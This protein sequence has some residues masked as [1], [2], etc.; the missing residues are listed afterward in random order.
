MEHLITEGHSWLDNFLSS[1]DHQ[2]SLLVLSGDEL[3]RRLRS[4]SLDLQYDRATEFSPNI[5]TLSMLAAK[6]AFLTY[7]PSSPD[8][9]VYESDIYYY[10][11]FPQCH[12]FVEEYD[13]F[14]RSII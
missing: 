14:K 10:K 3:A 5:K 4:K 13:E 12:S 11:N 2:K 1:P 6:V 8:L 9:R 7:G